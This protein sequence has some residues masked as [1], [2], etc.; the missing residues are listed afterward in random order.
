VEEKALGQESL[1]LAAALEDY[2]QDLRKL[3][4]EAQA[5]ELEERAKSIRAAQP[6][7]SASA[8]NGTAH[9]APASTKT[10]LP[11]SN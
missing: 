4:Q 11:K 9:T 1:T 3:A 5:G 10:S 7:T 6:K 2:A 8:G